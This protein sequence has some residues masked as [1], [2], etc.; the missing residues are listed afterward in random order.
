LIEGH[1]AL[2]GD[3]ELRHAAVDE[4]DNGRSAAAAWR[5]ASRAFAAEL[6]R[7]DDARMRERVADLRD[8]EDQVLAVLAGEA[9][10]ATRKVPAGSIVLADDLLPSHVMALEKQRVAGLCLARGGAT[11]HAAILAAASG[12]PMLVAAGPGVLAIANGTPL[13]LDAERGELQVDPPSTERA[14]SERNLAQRRETEAS[15]RAAAAAPAITRD[16]VRIAILVNLG[17]GD[18]V[19][20][21]LQQGAEGCGLLRTEFLFL[22]RHA[23]PTEDEQRAEYQRIATALAGRPL[24]VRTMD[25]GGDKPIPY[26]PMPHEENPALGLRGMRASLRDPELLRAQLRAIAAVE[27]AGCARVLLPM[28]TELDELRQ[29]REWL[30]EASQRVGRPMPALGVMIETPASALLAGQLAGLADFLSI[31]TNDLSQY[32]LAMDRGHP[33]LARRLDALHPAVLRLIAATVEG[34]ALH[35]RSVSVCGALA[36][37]EEALPILVGLGIRELSV[38]AGN[39]PRLKRRVRGLDVTDC[40]ALAAQARALDNASAVRALI[41]E[42]DAAVPMMAKEAR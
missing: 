21:A 30:R 29:V 25:V 26:L 33:E 9:P 28:V 41:R 2:L 11:S 8:L 36:G 24:S 18:D 17:G 32:T 40:K 22:D 31:G 6:D 7:L 1:I 5:S 13:V 39:I 12:I 10:G 42:R 20:A 19:G 35:G 23:A 15:D 37:D 38:A 16:D 27:P 14:A 3:P 34:A 4:I